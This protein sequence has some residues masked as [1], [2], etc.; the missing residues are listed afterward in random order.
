MIAV[1][2]RG[3]PTINNRPFRLTPPDATTE[4]GETTTKRIR[5]T[6]EDKVSMLGEKPKISMLSSPDWL[7]ALK[8]VH[9]SL[10]QLFPVKEVVSP[11]AGRIQKFINNW[12]KITNDPSVLEIVKG[13]EIP[14][15]ETPTQTKLPHGIQ[16]NSQ[17]E[18]AMDKEIESMLTKGAIREA[19]PKEDQFLSNVFVT[20]KGEEGE[21]RPITN[22]KQL[23]QYVPYHHFKME[24]LKDVKYLL[25]KG[26][27][28]CKIDLKDAYFSVPLGTRSRKLV[29]FKWKGILYEFLCLAF[30]LGPAPR[31]F[32]KLM[33]VPI[34]L[35][36]RL[37]IRLVIYLDD[38]LI[39]GSTI[40]EVARAR[41]T[42]M[43]LFYH[44]GLTINMKKSV[45]SPSQELE[46]LG[47]TINSLSMMF[48]L[49]K[50]KTQKLILLCQEGCKSP[51]MTLRNLCSLIGKL[52]ST[53]AA[54]TP[55][56]LQLRY[57]Q[58]CCIKAQAR[59]LHYETMISLSEEG[60]SELRWW[61]ENLNLAQGNRIHLPPPELIICSDAAK[62]GGWGAVCHLGS[63]G[64][65]WSEEE[66]QLH[67]NIQELLAAELA[68]KTFTKNH[69]PKSIH[70]KIDNTTA[71]SYLVNMGGTKNLTMIKISKRIWEYLLQHGITIT[72]EWIPSHLNVIADWESRNVKDSAEWK[73]CP[74]VFQSICRVM[75]QPETDLFAS[76]T[77][78]QLP[79]YYSWKADPKCLA[80][81]A[82]YQ[83]WT[84]GFPYAF[85][86]FCLMTR[87]IRQM[88][89]QSV[90]KMILITPLW[91]TQPWFPLAMA[92]SIKIPLL[93]P[94][95]HRLLLNP[96]GESHPLLQDSSLRLVAWLVSGIDSKVQEFR[97]E[98]RTSSSTPGEME[99]LSLMNQP[100]RG[101]PCGAVEG[102][103][104]PLHAL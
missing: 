78:H 84:Q 13:W 49:S 63:T 102:V 39:M 52:W 87:V 16:M 37:G 93:L 94:S 14:L 91:P 80:V 68:I 85:P 51:T 20:P 88:M 69:K 9:P 41:D 67:I 54:V 64:G 75:G 47:V 6:K 55:A 89:S 77:S 92:R 48:Y 27:W 81:D 28:M 79:Q 83:D 10:Q 82:F 5:L 98:L 31:I 18:Q 45:L 46:F 100:G 56:P 90:E 3:L 101:G 73:L 95:F 21:Y 57:L 66:L 19:I 2:Y 97:R 22:L 65:P 23:N 8:Q 43:Y 72:A 60:I 99:H 1:S 59:K 7:P 38:L 17:E 62:T 104:I 34:A 96:S 25:Q 29:R 44:L 33:K 86:P 11:Q 71:L 61:V 76:R 12:K 53:A 40:E 50:E 74:R 42:V 70:M 35:L 15:L 32:T 103:W 30:G 4:E 24:G 58:Q 36:R 26:D